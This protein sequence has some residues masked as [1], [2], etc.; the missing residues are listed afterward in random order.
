MKIVPVTAV[1]YLRTQPGDNVRFPNPY[2]AT[3]EQLRSVPY[4]AEVWSDDDGIIDYDFDTERIVITF[5]EILAD[6]NAWDQSEDDSH[7]DNVY[8]YLREC[9]DNG[10]HPC[11]L[12]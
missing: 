7:Y 4:I 9:I 5:D 12:L 10:F 8:E 1:E 11:K 3:E 6:F 2:D